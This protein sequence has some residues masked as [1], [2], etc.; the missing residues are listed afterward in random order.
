MMASSA[1]A[2]PSAPAAGLVARL[3]R[4]GPDGEIYEE[5]QLGVPRVH[6]L[7]RWGPFVPPE[8]VEGGAPGAWR[9][10]GALE[11]DLFTLGKRL[12][13]DA[14]LAFAWHLA[15]AV[16]ELHER[17]AA[18][19]ALHPR[20]IGLDGQGALRI[21]PALAERLSQDPDPGAGAVATDCL[22]L[23]D[24]FEA[25]G[26]Q[27]HRD[28]AIPLLLSAL[29][30]RPGRLRLSP[31]RA[32][33]QVL[34]AILARRPTAEVAL[35]DVLG[36]GWRLEDH[37]RDAG[38][39]GL[40]APRIAPRPQVVRVAAA[41]PPKAPPQRLVLTKV[42]RPASEVLGSTAPTA[43][44][45]TAP[46][47]TAPPPPRMEPEVELEPEGALSLRFHPE[48]APT[49]DPERA[50][51]DEPGTDT[52]PVIVPRGPEEEDTGTVYRD[53]DDEEDDSDDHLI[54]PT[55]I[56]VPR[57]ALLGDPEELQLDVA[58]EYVDDVDSEAESIHGGPAPL[59][60]ASLASAV[61][62][63]SVQEEPDDEPIEDEPTAPPLTPLVPVPPRAI[64]VKMAPVSVSPVS[65]SP[66]LAE[67]DPLARASEGAPRW[68]E[69]KGVGAG[70][71]REAELGMGKWS[72]AGRPLAEV[73]A[74]MSAAPSRKLELEAEGAR[75]PIWLG[76]ALL[77][78]A[79]I[80][81]WIAG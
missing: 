35:V 16:A 4:R 32:V 59:P 27:R 69:A 61:A 42:T 70:A 7:P 41:P 3:I 34:G 48:D 28:P 25:L 67:A 62:P 77:F 55:P 58:E 73:A 26:L 33:R 43:P 68:G 37:Y 38:E 30:R 80:L 29:R 11:E 71:G 72:E 78:G 57:A 31:G 47:P 74:E 53:E 12:S 76:A 81:W 17:G 22:R 19:G 50:L 6:A 20:S 8:P 24:C 9:F 51:T 10:A 5:D 64:A 23:A 65:V 21:R 40:S 46:P 54:A 56:A 15:A 14:A 18:H 45:P 44:F 79:L 60:I 52:G 66:V 49:P 63:P 36:H 2:G 13:A 1:A 75:W 39:A